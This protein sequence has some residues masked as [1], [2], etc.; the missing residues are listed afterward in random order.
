[1]IGLS[2]LART[3]LRRISGAVA[4]VRGEGTAR[5]VLRSDFFRTA[6]RSLE[7]E[8]VAR[9]ATA[10]LRDDWAC[11]NAVWFPVGTL[12]TVAFQPG[13]VRDSVSSA[14]PMTD[15]GYRELFTRWGASAP[16]SEPT[17]EGPLVMAVVGERWDVI[18]P[19]ASPDSVRRGEILGYLVLVKC[20]NW[21]QV[22]RKPLFRLQL[23]ALADRMDQAL[24]YEAVRALTFKDELTDLFNQRYLPV[25]LDQQIKRA[26]QS[27]GRFSVLFVDV[28]RFKSV[29]DQNGHLV[30]SQILIKLSRLLR[31]TVRRTDYAFRYGGDE[32]VIVLPG[33]DAR[34]A[35]ITAERIRRLTE[36]AT[37]ELDGDLEVSVTVSIGV[38]AFPEHANS[39]LDLLRLADE[40]MYAGKRESRNA[41]RIAS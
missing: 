25:V 27:D 4:D 14:L 2:Q 24:S 10:W 13:A 12:G 36:G 40:A 29:N 31:S 8:R 6:I 15:G 3:L 17:A 1:M 26:L 22:E 33:A 32:Y 9:T 35:M 23:A 18:V 16:A 34:G 11:D 37:F 41:V 30:G 39:T 38:A 19:V 21:P 7:P 20:P 5:S 28:D